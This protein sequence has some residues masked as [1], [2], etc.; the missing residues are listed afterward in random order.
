MA[1]RCRHRDRYAAVPPPARTRPQPLLLLGAIRSEDAA[2]NAALV[3]TLDALRHSGQLSELHLGTLS[4][5]ET[6]ELAELTAGA[7]IAPERAATLYAFSEGQP[8]F[9]IESLRS[10]LEASTTL[11]TDPPAAPAE[12]FGPTQIPAKIYRLIAARLSRLS[13]AGQEVIAA[14]AALALDESALVNG[15]DE[16]WTRRIVR[17]QPGDGYDFSRIIFTFIDC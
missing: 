3:A 17:E 4:L 10:S 6:T 5:E 9:L 13:P 2:G 12:P 15:L 16:L 7:P 14:A 11:D 1:G 8:L